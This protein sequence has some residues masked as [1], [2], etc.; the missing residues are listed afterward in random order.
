M[1]NRFCRDE[2]KYNTPAYTSVCARKT[3]AQISLGLRSRPISIGNRK[4]LEYART[5]VI[6]K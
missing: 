1:I 2:Y 3:R 6:F 4:T 5:A